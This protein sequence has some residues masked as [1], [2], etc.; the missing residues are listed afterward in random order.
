MICYLTS[1]AYAQDSAGRYEFHIEERDLG[2]AIEAI[3]RHT[4][5][6]V[7]FPYELADA[8][9]LN[10][11]IG[12]YTLE[13]A[14]QI[15]L[16]GTDFTGGLSD[17]GVMFIALS[18]ATVEQDREGE[19]NTT[20]IKKGLLA[21]VS[22]F[23]FGAGGDAVAQDNGKA[24]LNESGNDVIV[25]TAQRREQALTEVPMSVVAIDSVELRDRGVTN[26]VDLGFA[27]P[28]LAVQSNGGNTTRLTVRGVGNSAGFS[29]PLVGLYL[30][31]VSVSGNPAYTLDLRPYDLE[32]VEVL[33]GP[34]GTLFG[35]GSVGGTIRFITN[36]PD[37]DDFAAE[38]DLEF[39]FT[40]DGAPSQKAQSVVN[41][42]IVQDQLAVRVV[43]TFEH[44]GGW[45]DMPIQRREN[46]NGADVVNIRSTLLWR[47]TERFAA[48]G[49]AIV[50]RNDSVLTAR[51]DEDGNYT[52]F[53]GQTWEQDAE[54]DYELYGLTLSYDFG[55]ATLTSITSHIDAVRSNLAESEIPFL[56]APLEPFGSA[57]FNEVSTEVFN[58]ELQL[59][60]NGSGPVNWLIGATYRDREI[61][62][63]FENY[64]APVSSPLPAP[65]LGLDAQNTEAWAIFGEAGYELTEW[66]EI[67]GGLRYFEDDR[68]QFDG[69]TEQ[70][71]K[72]DAL[73]PRAFVRVKLTDAVNVYANVAKG[74]R[75]GGF[76]L[77]GQP[78]FDPEDI[79]TYEVGAKGTAFDDRLYVEASVYYSE[80][81]DFQTV[82]IDPNVGLAITSNGGDGEIIGLD[83]T[84]GL[85]V[86]DNFTVDF[87]GSYVD[88]EVVSLSVANAPIAIGDRLPFVPEYNFT[89]SPV[90]SF[91]IASIP[92]FVRLDYSQQGVSKVF[93]RDFPSGSVTSS[94]VINMLNATVQFDVTQNVSLG[95]FGTNLADDRGFTDGFGEINQTRSRPRTIG[96]R[97]RLTY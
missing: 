93:Q 61:V 35:D 30:D 52:P 58:Q 29:A 96:A 95:V 87:S 46:I 78:T 20:T 14:L 43:G 39:A 81:S 66:I 45:I 83:W 89:V 5:K 76:N 36:R 54:D 34:Q 32:R 31:D 8:T 73:S 37:L 18:D 53:F 17:N 49:L 9:G 74:F 13:E 88:T 70:S 42:P 7:L 69:N 25:V 57:L 28:G 24:V 1:W 79:W 47:P 15:L 92:G 4:D 38:V 75:S 6:N 67:G 80:Y 97:V 72:F 10:P 3:V 55:P 50:H 86:T 27:V 19:V 2:S 77:L 62:Q 63:N 51:E 12:S 84:I 90:Y 21:S 48:T 68:S 56:P 59:A 91:E 44:A 23:L 11:V 71:A 41:I 26:L 16:Q 33:R 64:F 85:N 40:E 60:S 65:F 82:G 94:D 22:A